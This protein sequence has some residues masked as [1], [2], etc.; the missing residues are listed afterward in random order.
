M[1]QRFP[2]RARPLV[3]VAAITFASFG[4]AAAAHVAKRGPD[5]YARLAVLQVVLAPPDKLPEDALA[6]LKK[7]GPRGVPAIASRAKEGPI[8]DELF[9]ILAA[10]AGEPEIELLAASAVGA[11]EARRRDALLALAR[12]HSEAAA[13][14]AGP[15]LADTSPDVRN[16][17]RE[18]LR[19]HPESVLSAA[20]A[21]CMGS[22]SFSPEFVAEVL[23]DEGLVS[24]AV[25]PVSA[26]LRSGE[27]IR[28]YNALYLAR[29]T[30]PRFPPGAGREAALVLGISTA[31]PRFEPG[32]Q[33]LAIEVLAALS[34]PASLEALCEVAAS[35]KM[36]VPARLQAIE[37]LGGR[38]DPRVSATLDKLVRVERSE[39]R[40]AAAEALGRVG[41]EED[42]A[43][44][45]EKIERGEVD[46][47]ER[48]ALLRAISVAGSVAL[49]PRLLVL[50]RTVDSD[51]LQKAIQQIAAKDP[52]ACIPSLMDELSS[53]QPTPL[54][55]IDDELRA[56][57]GHQPPW[58]GTWR[59]MAAFEK[60]RAALHKDWAFWWNLNKENA[61]D[62]WHVSAQRE[63]EDGL[64]SPKGVDRASAV[65]RLA[66]LSPANLEERL[67]PLFD[68]PEEIVWVRVQDALAD[69]PS[70]S[71]NEL[72]R[73]RLAA[74]TAREQARV[75]RLLG[76]RSDLSAVDPLLQ[77][78][79]SESAAVRRECARALGK[80]SDRR[81]SRPL[82]TL[83]RDPANDV[84]DA[85]RDAV[86]E[87][88]DRSVAADLLRG[89]DSE[90]ADF[91]LSC[92][93]L[94]GRCGTKAAV[95]PLV[96]FFHDKSQAVQDSAIGSF[97]SL[98][99]IRPS[100]LDPGEQELRRWEELV[101]RRQK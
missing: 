80:L 70:L 43:R 92:I 95:R 40:V 60:E 38:R 42:A 56:L 63:A 18:A 32:A 20:V 75:A 81:A 101:E 27:P 94:L 10:S 65:V 73:G 3:A 39:V 90:D 96:G 26:G 19:G 98:T 15:A 85:A 99:G 76:L 29:A 53:A 78:L 61:P 54:K 34:G 86:A 16:A 55:W 17:A 50:S 45:L 13:R 77:L 1:S 66:R 79:S 33:L 37:A 83:L 64:R 48:E 87:L 36:S 28:V 62:E 23:V 91:R 4:I 72:I 22:S 6:F 7:F 31:L 68:D 69:R 46:V 82:V 52:K 41:T 2:R 35:R 89:L 21:D 9:A 71:G 24:A 74:G 57:T 97:Q 14:A 58:S 51:R 88:A 59:T 30:F 8:P 93:Q 100:V 49:A 44:W 5:L 11:V 25:G 12:I 84:R 47:E 67:V